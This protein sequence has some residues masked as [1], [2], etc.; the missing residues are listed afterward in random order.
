MLGLGRK[1]WERN[2]CRGAQGI[3]VNAI[4]VDRHIVA[5]EL[6]GSSV[7]RKCKVEFEEQ[8]NVKLEK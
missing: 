3:P 4:C 6:L 2:Q 1:E 7:G 5:G 8:W